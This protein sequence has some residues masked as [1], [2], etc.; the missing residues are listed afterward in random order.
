MEVAGSGQGDGRPGSRRIKLWD[1]PVR[2]AHWSFVILLPA[3]WWTSE[4]DQMSLHRWLGYGMLGLIVFR[5]YWGFAGSS[6]ARFAGFL[7]GPGTVAAY[8]RALFAS[9]AVSG[10][11]HSPL[12]ALSVVALLGLLLAQIIL[13]L[14]AQDVD[15]LEAGPLAR[16]VSYGVAEA[17]RDW[18]GVVF[19][20]LLW[21]V[22]LHLAA[23]TFYL[24]VKRDNL[25]GPMFTGW[26]KV[27][28][29]TQDPQFAPFWRLISGI[30]LGCATA[31]WVSLGAPL[32]GWVS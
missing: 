12:G 29:E 1:W 10:A 11:G 17:A 28:A 14:F 13:G 4:N 31:G 8:V 19:D 3:L 21:L 18:H 16:H 6:P 24:L 32:P 15:G 30:L 20:A 2:I 22:G 27:S 7:K 9:K 25:I 26:K 23:V 5:L